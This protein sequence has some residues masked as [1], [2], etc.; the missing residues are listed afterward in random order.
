[1]HSAESFKISFRGEINCF[2]SAT[3]LLAAAEMPEYSN[4]TRGCGFAATA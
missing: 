2:G 4:L 1:V 3:I